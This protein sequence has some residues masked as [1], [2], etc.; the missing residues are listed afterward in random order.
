MDNPIH[1]INHYRVDSA[2]G[3]CNTCPLHSDLSGGYCYPTFEQ[4]GPGESSLVCNSGF[5][6]TSVFVYRHCI[7]SLEIMG[8]CARPENSRWI[9]WPLAQVG[10]GGE[11]RASEASAPSNCRKKKRKEIRLWIFLR[12][13][14]KSLSIFSVYTFHFFHR[15]CNTWWS[16]VVSVVYVSKK[17]SNSHARYKMLYDSVREQGE[18]TLVIFPSLA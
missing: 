8:S 17:S 2:I 13:K 1:Q 12:Y 15:N 14:Y 7:L 18:S 3:F 10:G 11:E 4:L 16:N 9:Y 6:F 5:A